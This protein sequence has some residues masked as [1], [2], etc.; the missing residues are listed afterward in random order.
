MADDE[1]KSDVSSEKPSSDATS[2]DLPDVSAASSAHSGDEVEVE[3][4]RHLEDDDLLDAEMTVGVA[5]DKSASHF[6]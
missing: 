2:P 6:K 4:Q 1:Q 5:V 3:T